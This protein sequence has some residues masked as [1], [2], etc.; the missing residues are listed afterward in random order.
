MRSIDRNPLHLAL[1]LWLLRQLDREHAVS[2]GRLDLL[3]IDIVAH[4]YG[5]LERALPALAVKPAV[6]YDLLVAL[7][8][9]YALLQRDVQAL[10]RAPNVPRGGYFLFVGTLERRKNLGVLLTAYERLLSRNPNVPELVVA[11]RATEDAAEWLG[12]MNGPPLAGRV[13]YIGYV[14]EAERERLYAGARVL[15]LPSLDEG[16]GLTA[17]EAMSAG[18]AVVAS[19]RGSLP[20]VLGGAGTLVDPSDADA[21][22]VAI[23]RLLPDEAA[24]AAG[25]AGLDRSRSFRWDEAAATLRR[26]YADAVARRRNQ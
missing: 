22:S 11:G 25:A 17:L 13:R 10:G 15:I 21:L 7:Q 1:R 5:A 16:F 4:G 3:R 8:S 26:A 19:E 2:E 14:A 9:E 23:E 6:I 24:A 12:R 20:E 18:I